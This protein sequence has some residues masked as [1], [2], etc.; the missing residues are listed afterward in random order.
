MIAA[1]RS[2]HDA[3]ANRDAESVEPWETGADATAQAAKKYR[4]VR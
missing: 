4:I 3:G 2:G 1:E